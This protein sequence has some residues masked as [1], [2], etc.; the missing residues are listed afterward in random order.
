MTGSVLFSNYLLDGEPDEAGRQVSQLLLGNLLAPVTMAI[1]NLGIS[2]MLAGKALTADEVA[3]VAGT[4]PN[5]TARLLQAGMAVGLL[6]ADSSGRFT[7][8][9]MGDWLRPDASPIGDLTGFWS[10]PMVTAMAGLADHVRSGRK[11]DPAAPGGLWEY[12][13]S[14]PADAARFSRAMGYITARMLAALTASDYRPPPCRR[15]VDAG[16][17]RGTLLAWL[18]QMV[19]EAVGVLF[20]RPES[21]AAAPGYLAAAG[22]ADRTELVAGNFLAEVPE[23][24]L[25]VLSQVLHN[26]DDENVRRIVANCARSARP[27]GWLIVIEYV[28]PPVPEPA[29]G[30][31]LDIL[32]M[33]LFGGRER[34]REE[35]QALIE[36]TGYT[37]IREVPLTVGNTGQQPP[38]RIMEFCRD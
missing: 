19:P 3:A 29:V 4:D 23:G 31:M 28:L 24:D 2:G 35:H 12:L 16:G 14:H 32:M 20:D 6:A 17:S 18:L 5:A 15:I 7:L 36:P 13:G 1:V 37:F 10:A 22:V 11:V 27:G 38:W 21:L 8:T 26:W 25:H 33:V 34:R 9:K 30:H